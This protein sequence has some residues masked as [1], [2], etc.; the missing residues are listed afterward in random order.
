MTSYLKSQKSFLNENK[1][2]NPYKPA[3]KDENDIHSYIRC[4]TICYNKVSV[5]TPDNH[6][7]SLDS[8]VIVVIWAC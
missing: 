7:S 2:W 6:S 4:T 3:K 5:L 8:V 1:G